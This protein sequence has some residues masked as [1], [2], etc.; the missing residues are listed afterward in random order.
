[1]KY[2]RGSSEKQAWKIWN[3]GQEDMKFTRY[4]DMKFTRQEDMKCKV[5][6][7]EIQ[8]TQI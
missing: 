7:Y 8:G 6:R 3:T 5:G 2:K 1:M 4:E